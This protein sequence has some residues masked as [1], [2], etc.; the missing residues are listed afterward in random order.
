MKYIT[1][2][3]TYVITHF[4][5]IIAILILALIIFNKINKNN[6][7]QLELKKKIIETE[8]RSKEELLAS[9]EREAR[10][11]HE[12]NRKTLDMKAAKLKRELIEKEKDR[13]LVNN[14]YSENLAK[15]KD[16]KNARE[17]VEEMLRS[18]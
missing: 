16:V 15:L 17:L 11:E 6:R 18:W 5:W 12:Y 10:L 14:T 2:T 13:I 8:K 9:A 7:E 3:I 1:K 4:W